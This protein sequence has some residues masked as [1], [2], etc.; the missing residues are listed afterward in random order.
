MTNNI[1]PVELYTETLADRTIETLDVAPGQVIWIWASTHS[2]DLIEALALRIPKRG[3]FWTLRLSIE[4][5]SQRIGQTVSERYL[6]LIPEHELR[7]LS[8][9]DAIVAVKDHEWHSLDVSLARRR[10]MAAEWIA[11]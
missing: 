1:P 2:L 8:D 7:W 9:I 11:L 3:A 10:T 6:G 5:L 4:S